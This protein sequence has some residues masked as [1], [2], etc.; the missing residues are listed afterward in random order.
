VGLER[1]LEI[2]PVLEA[3]V[4]EVQL[5]DKLNLVAMR[6]AATWEMVSCDVE[7]LF[8]VLDS[9]V[10]APAE[11]DL[12]RGVGREEMGDEALPFDRTAATVVVLVDFAGSLPDDECNQVEA[13]AVAEEERERELEHPTGVLVGR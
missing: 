10:V 3:V 6:H 8:V 9:A 12:H 7:A 5:P 1:E 11:V 13:A 4:E 2:G